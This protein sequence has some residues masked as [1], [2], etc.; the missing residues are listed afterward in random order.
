M[1]SALRQVQLR[2]I[3]QGQGS[4]EETGYRLQPG[5][6]GCAGFNMNGRPSDA[7]QKARVAAV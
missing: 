4:R 6:A 5:T 7:R 2:R 1:G 3:R